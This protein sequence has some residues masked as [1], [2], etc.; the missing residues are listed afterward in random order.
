MV[1]CIFCIILFFDFGIFCFRVLY[2]FK[3]LLLL[4]CVIF[5]FI[6]LI[7][8][9]EVDILNI[10]CGVINFLVND[11]FFLLEIFFILVFR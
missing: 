10:S 2:I 11:I 9:L 7:V 8:E 6:D 4:I 3:F 1:E 5:N